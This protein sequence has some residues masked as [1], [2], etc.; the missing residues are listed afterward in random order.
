VTVDG[1]Q[2]PGDCAAIKKFQNRCAVGLASVGTPVRV[3]G[4]RPGT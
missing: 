3:F 2:S 4:P 1:A